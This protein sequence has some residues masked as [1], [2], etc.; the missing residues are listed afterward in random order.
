MKIITR[1]LQPEIEKWLFRRKIII[2]YG[3]RQV[4][5]T[6][7]VKSILDQYGENG[8]Y[9]NCEIQSV[10]NALSHEEPAQIKRWVDKS[11]FEQLI[12]E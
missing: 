11:N 3:A 2:L 7:L 8:G 9:Y 5:K 6:T 1:Y 4:G 12:M 10:K